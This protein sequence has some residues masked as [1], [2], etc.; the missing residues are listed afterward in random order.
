MFSH[1]TEPNGNVL[2]ASGVEPMVEVVDDDDDDDDDDDIQGEGQ[3]MHP[4][5]TRSDLSV[6][7]AKLQAI[8]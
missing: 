7:C 8:F 2:R 6:L 3:G 5:P 4:L 1:S